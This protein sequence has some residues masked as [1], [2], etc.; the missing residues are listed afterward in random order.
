MAGVASGNWSAIRSRIHAVVS[1]KDCS[2]DDPMYIPVLFSQGFP[3]RHPESH[4]LRYLHL[5][6]TD[7]LFGQHPVQSGIDNRSS[8]GK[9]HIEP[10]RWPYPKMDHGKPS[11]KEI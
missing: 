8:K 10:S 11:A 5:S 1:G 7:N 3:F 2:L 9:S 6:T 4:A